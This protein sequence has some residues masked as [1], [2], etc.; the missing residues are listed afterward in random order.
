[1]ILNN[2]TTAHDAIASGRI[3]LSGIQRRQAKVS[4]GGSFTV[5][6]FR[7]QQLTTTYTF[8]GSL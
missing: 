8:H 3:A 7:Y 6:R 2:D 1:V 4:T 5:S